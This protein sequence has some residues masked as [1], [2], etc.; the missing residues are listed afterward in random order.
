MGSVGC[1]GQIENIKRQ[2]LIINITNAIAR[3]NHLGR[4]PQF[5]VQKVQQLSRSYCYTSRDS[6]Y[7]SFLINIWTI[8]IIRM[9]LIQL[10]NEMINSFIYNY[11]SVR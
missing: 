5:I 9:L 4:N 1:F 2:S 7:A 3:R 10:S 11:I 8:S 6:S